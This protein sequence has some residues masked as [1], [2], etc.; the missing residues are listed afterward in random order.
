MTLLIIKGKMMRLSLIILTLLASGCAT[1]VISSTPRSVIVESELMDITEAQK[2]ADSECA[3]HNRF[4]R[5]TMR[6]T[7]SDKTYTFDCVQ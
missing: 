7:R 5:I 3:K 2:L 6:A 1:K 4:A